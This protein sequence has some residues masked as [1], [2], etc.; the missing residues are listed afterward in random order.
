MAFEFIFTEDHREQ[1]LNRFSTEVLEALED[2]MEKKEEELQYFD[3]V[4]R[5]GKRFY[6]VVGGGSPTVHFP[7]MQFTVNNRSFRAVFVLLGTVKRLVFYRCLEKSG[8][9]GRRR[10]SQVLQGL[11][12]NPNQVKSKAE[13]ILLETGNY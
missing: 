1:V 5:V 4:E 12:E 8:Q 13:E 10:Q 11:R 9:H 2:S 7:Y 6:N 3:R